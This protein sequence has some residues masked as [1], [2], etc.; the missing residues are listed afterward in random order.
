[1]RVKA[2]DRMVLSGAQLT[3][4]Q[5]KLVVDYLALTYP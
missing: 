3:D 1:M 2:V 5:V 4:E